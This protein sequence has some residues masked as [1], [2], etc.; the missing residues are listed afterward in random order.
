MNTCA[1]I[2]ADGKFVQ[3]NPMISKSEF[4][5]TLDR[6]SRDVGVEN[7]M[8]KDNAPEYAVYNT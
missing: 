7:E 3:I 6:I 2:F 8:F 1:Q 4:G 5:T